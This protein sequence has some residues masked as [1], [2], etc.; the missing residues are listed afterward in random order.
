[1]RLLVA[2]GNPDGFFQLAVLQRAGDLGSE[3]PRLVAG[4]AEIQKKFLTG[5]FS[6]AAIG[7]ALAG[8]AFTTT[9]RGGEMAISGIFMA[10]ISGGLALFACTSARRY[11]KRVGP[12]P[13]PPVSQDFGA[14]A[15]ET[16]TEH[17]AQDDLTYTPNA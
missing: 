16:H 9:D 10:V 14:S 8:Y 4:G 1:M 7:I 2:V 13:L 11:Q 15:A 17:P 3:L 12:K 5:C 6:V